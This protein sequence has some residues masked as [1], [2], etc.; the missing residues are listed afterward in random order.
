VGGDQKW[1][2]RWPGKE[3][4][5]E[6]DRRPDQITD[7]QDQIEKDRME[8]PPDYHLNIITESF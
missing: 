2:V 4:E 8:N 5:K 7:R 3:G 6:G 1:F